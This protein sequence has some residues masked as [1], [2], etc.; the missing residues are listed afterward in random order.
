[1][2]LWAPGRVEWFLK[3]AKPQNFKAMFS[4]QN[5]AVP[6]QVAEALCPLTV[7]NVEGRWAM[8]AWL[9]NFMAGISGP[10]K[11]KNRRMTN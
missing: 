5:T 3:C 11:D 4:L 9:F 6:G 2:L 8:R 1:M 7:V 10:R